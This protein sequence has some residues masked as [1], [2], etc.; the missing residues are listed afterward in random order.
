MESRNRIM[1]KAPPFDLYIFDLDGTL[2][3]SQYDLCDAVNYALGQLGRPPI[4]VAQ[5]PALLGEGITRLLER[6]L[7]TAEVEVVAEA[8]RHFDAYY[9]RHYTCK[10]RPYAGVE[11]VLSR[12][13]FA[14]KAV[15]SNKHHPFT[16]G[17]IHAL[18]L[19]VHFDLVLGAQPEKYRLKPAPDSILFILDRLEV[20]PH[21]ALIVG[22]STHDIEAGKAAGI[23]TCAVTYGY[24][25]AE[26]LRAAQ[27][28]LLIDD[29]RQLPTKVWNSES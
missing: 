26:L 16:L 24:R 20:P 4:H 2:V 7:D 25:P 5:M 19:D 18:K 3:N 22:D 12:L 21:R 8:R 23:A 9:H 28:D 6:V 1:C 17:I 10:T 14:K 15:C 11:E 13:A 27:P 29:I